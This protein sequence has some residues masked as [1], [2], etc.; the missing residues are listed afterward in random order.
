MS[1]VKDEVRN[2]AYDGIREYNNPLPNW[3]LMTFYGT[4]IFAIIYYAHYELGS[5]QSNA[6]ELQEALAKIEQ[7]K[8]SQPQSA[9]ASEGDLEA[10]MNN[11]QF[12]ESGAKVYTT[13]CASCHGAQ[14][15]GLIG[16]NL[17]DKYWLHGKGTRADIVKVVTDGVPEKGM[18]AWG[19][20]LKSDDVLAVAGYVFKHI[21]TSPPNP[22]APQG[23][24]VQ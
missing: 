13:T 18:P 21:G 20:V 2:H 14:L 24:E 22:K 3:W 23:E 9:V 6:Q 15:Q 7:L 19:A 11:P 1:E 8:A 16:P 4:I 5:G 17:T 12:I 10:K